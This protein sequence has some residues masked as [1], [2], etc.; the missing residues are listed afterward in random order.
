MANAPLTSADLTSINQSL[1]SLNDLISEINKAESCGVDC[2]M[3]KDMHTSLTQQLTQ[4]KAT[5]FP[6]KP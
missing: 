2:Q 6:N 5:Y 4:M 1:K 3:F